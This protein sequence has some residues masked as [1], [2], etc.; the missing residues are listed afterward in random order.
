TALV[1]REAVTIN[2]TEHF[3]IA[4]HHWSCS[5]APIRDADGTIIGVIDISCMTDNKH[6]F[7]LGMASTVAYAIEREIQVEQKRREME[8]ITHC[9]QQ[10]EADEPYVVCNEK[11]QIVSASR[12]IRDRFSDWHGMDVE[13]LKDHSFVIRG[14]QIIQSEQDGMV[15]GISLS[16]EEAAKS[17][18]TVS[19]A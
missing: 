1:I 13:R 16:L 4:S 11:K 12:S 7:M 6:P 8:L 3:S 9:L 2:G 15:L 5:A 19:F 17:S 14:K 18:M 10:V